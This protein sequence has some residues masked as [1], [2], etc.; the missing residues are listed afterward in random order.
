MTASPHITLGRP[1]S[2]PVTEWPLIERQIWAYVRHKALPDEPAVSFDDIPETHFDYRCA[3]LSRESLRM[4]EWAYGSLLAYVR[5]NAPERYELPIGERFNEAS[6]QA[7]IV[8]VAA[9]NTPISV[10]NMVAFIRR[11]LVRIDQTGNWTR[12]REIQNWYHR[13]V[14]RTFDAKAFRL[15]DELVAL[16]DVLK[17]AAYDALCADRA[18]GGSGTYRIFE[19]YRDG[20]MIKLLALVP[21]RKDNFRRLRWRVLPGADVRS[22]GLAKRDAVSL[23][24]TSDGYEID[25][26][27]EVVKTKVGLR[28]LLTHELEV[29]IDLFRSQFQPLAGP[30]AVA[31]G[32]LWC[33]RQTG[34][35][36]KTT[37]NKIIGDRTRAAFGVALSPHDFRSSAASTAA[38]FVP[39]EPGLTGSVN[40]HAP[41]GRIYESHYSAPVR[42]DAA[43]ARV[44]DS[45]S[46]FRRKLPGSI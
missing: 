17:D 40:G 31:A 43:S 7:F 15:T 27:K 21:L 25:V 11:A 6:I 32:Y 37:I 26:A 45:F 24:P 10:V 9:T 5:E 1:E 29:D 8:C 22:R 35:L 44:A 12:W 4:V 18:S 13:R 38:I 23:T 34:S 20:L 46:S 42:L 2:L 19:D 39:D 30:H 14:E 36:D 16:G 41:G 3:P 33:S 28:R